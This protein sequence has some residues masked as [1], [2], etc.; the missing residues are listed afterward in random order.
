MSSKCERCKHF[1]TITEQQLYCSE[2]EM[3]SG[4]VLDWCKKQ[5]ELIGYIEMCGFNTSD[6][7]LYEDRADNWFPDFETFERDDE[8]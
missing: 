2:P 1:G 6:C 5:K 7:E 8:E 3:G 4:R